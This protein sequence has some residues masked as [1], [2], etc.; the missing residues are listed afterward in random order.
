MRLKTIFHESFSLSRPSIHQILSVSLS[1]LDLEDYESRFDALRAVTQLGSNYIK[2]MPRY[3]YGSGLLDSDN[4]LTAFGAAVNSQDSLLELPQTQWLMHYFL[5]APLGPGP[6]FWYELVTQRFRI[7]DVFA[8]EEI[9]SQIAEIYEREEGKSLADRSARSTAT[10]FLGTY[11]KPEG[12]GNLRILEKIG[13]SNYIVLE[14][15]S[16]PKWAIA[17]ALAAF[18]QIRYPD[19]TTIHLNDLYTEGYF[20]DIFL[21]GKGDFNRTLEDL[22]REGVLEVFRVA[23][24]YQV[25]LLN[26]EM[27][28]FLEKMYGDD[29]DR[30]PD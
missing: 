17:C 27:D 8:P 28:Y 3:C 16:P 13:D 26:R 24:P 15:P 29:I 5:S 11:T 10:V 21:I 18:W 4:N 25:A 12:L 23:P 20:T 14:P 2:S 19:M 7:G 9:A 1:I 22:Q 6:K 30:G